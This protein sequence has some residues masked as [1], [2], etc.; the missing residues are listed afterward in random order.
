MLG[1][2]KSKEDARLLLS[3]MWELPGKR[4]SGTMYKV[5]S[6]LHVTDYVYTFHLFRMLKY[7]HS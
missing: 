7:L 1:K 3:P 2:Q 6:S 4:V 5:G